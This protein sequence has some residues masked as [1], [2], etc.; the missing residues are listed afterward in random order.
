MILN[1]K[2]FLLLT[3]LAFQVFTSWGQNGNNSNKI[4]ALQLVLENKQVIGLTDKDLNDAIVSSSYT[5][6][7]TGMT[8]VYLQQTYKGIPVFNKMQVLAFKEGKLVS[9]AGKFIP[10]MDK[11]SAGSSGYPSLAADQAVR[12]AFAEEKLVA[13]ALS[14]LG[15]SENGS[16]IDY[17]KPAGVTENVIANLFWFP[18]EKDS[19]VT[20]ELGWQVQVAPAGTDDVWHVRLNAST[21]R[22][23][24]KINIVVFEDFKIDRKPQQTVGIGGGR[25][26]YIH[27]EFGIEINKEEKQHS[28]NAV[29][30]AN[31]LVIPY[32]Y[33]APSFSPAA[34]R[35][36]PWTAAPGNATTLGWH[37]DGT[38]DYIISRGNNVW[39]TEDTSGTNQNVGLPATSTTSPDPLNFSFT[40]NY[41]VEPSI[42]PN[43][44]QFCITNL[45]YWNNIVHDITYQYG[46]DEV[47]GNY[48]QNNLGR[49]GVG[50]DY[51]TALAQSGAAG[52]IGN[53]ANFLPTVD[54]VKGRMRMYLL[55][56]L[57]HCM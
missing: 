44:Q 16:V 47:G 4:A 28:P 39:A 1:M 56:L 10:D 29:A 43:M 14:I 57:P 33:E 8:M 48:Q 24:E 6:P 21:G 31:Y 13:P 34:T 3:L 15:S 25:K 38:T 18:K 12:L 19:L 55:I 7:S 35:S 41:G 11:V 26:Q 37:S 23:I 32:P 50:N 9:N 53:N 27:P 36:N 45:F 54:G 17:G 46:F 52:H 22:L 49:G 20:A 51:V 5:V 42:N 2:K 30:N 40:P